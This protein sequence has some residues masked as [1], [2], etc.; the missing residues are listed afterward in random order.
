M[1]T[2]TDK[3]FIYK[4]AWQLFCSGTSIRQL[5]KY[6]GIP[7]A[8]L[9]YRFQK[10]YGKDYCQYQNLNGVVQIIDEYLKRRDLTPVQKQQILEWKERR[11]SEILEVDFSNRE[12]RLLTERQM[13]T[14]TRQECHHPKDDWRNR[15]SELH[16]KK[17]I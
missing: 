13:N 1:K 3:D 17:T 9:Q 12:T 8:T 10:L 11:L 4:R 2:N 15:I 6:F 16:F 5:A 14:L 7:R